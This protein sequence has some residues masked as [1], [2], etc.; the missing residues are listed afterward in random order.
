MDDLFNPYFPLRLVPEEYAWFS[1]QTDS[2]IT[3]GS[4]GQLAG[5]ADASL[6]GGLLLSLKS[7]VST[8]ASKTETRFLEGATE[9]AAFGVAKIDNPEVTIFSIFILSKDRGHV[10]KQTVERAVELT[11]SFGRELL[12]LKEL[13]AY[14]ESGKQIPEDVMLRAFLKAAVVARLNLKITRVDNNLVQEFKNEATNLLKDKKFIIDQ[15]DRFFSTKGWKIKADYW[16]DGMLKRHL[17]EGLINRLTLRILNQTLGNNPMNLLFADHKKDLIRTLE[18]IVRLKIDDLLPSPSDLIIEQ[19]PKEIKKGYG[20]S[21]AKAQLKTL[22]NVE[23]ILYNL[24]VRRALLNVMKVH[25]LILLVDLSKS[26]ISKKFN[27]ALPEVKTINVGSYF[28]KALRPLVNPREHRF[29]TKFYNLFMEELKGLEAS[30]TT[31]D[32]FVTFATAFTDLK[33]LRKEILALDDY[34]IDGRWKKELDKR[35][36][37]PKGQSIKVQSLIES[38]RLLNA[39][40]KSSLETF[41]SMLHDQFIRAFDSSIGYLLEAMIDLYL[42][43]GPIVK[44]SSVITDLITVL[45]ENPLG[46]GFFVPLPKD[47]LLV[48]MEKGEV[49]VFH[50]EKPI[51]LSKDGT[52]RLD[53]EQM[54]PNKFFGSYSY[55]V[56]Y[57]SKIYTDVWRTI[58]PEMLLGLLQSP[59]ILY[60][61]TLNS[62]IRKFRFSVI[63]VVEEWIKNF[64]SELEVADKLFGKNKIEDK[65]LFNQLQFEFFKDQTVSLEGLPFVIREI[66]EHLPERMEKIARD[67]LLVWNSI[68][69]EVNNYSSKT[70]KTWSTLKKNTL[71]ELKNFEKSLT[72]EAKLTEKLISDILKPFQKIIRNIPKTS[73]ESILNFEEGSI[74]RLPSKDF[75]SEKIQNLL[76]KTHQFSEVELENVKL[77][78]SLSIFAESPQIYLEDAYDQI[79][80]NKKSKI[81]E[82]TQKAASSKK[83]FEMLLGENA[84]SIL[85]EFYKRIATIVKS[86]EELYIDNDAP[87]FVETRAIFLQLGEVRVEDIENSDLLNSALNFP[88]IH[89]ERQ[90]TKWVIKYQ[91]PFFAGEDMEIPDLITLSDALRFITLMKFKETTDRVNEG[92]SKVLSLISQNSA[93]TYDSVM[94]KLYEVILYS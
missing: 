76:H 28:E 45:Q 61:A 23:E 69:L 73:A 71:K 2:G 82:K 36:I 33:S 12:H 47:F 53:E 24:Y 31:Y 30:Q 13:P 92:I 60:K 51:V 62:G 19:L 75:V 65:S 1:I 83:E 90:T 85:E 50:D 16:E 93:E 78:L 72:K 48:A 49:E 89:L 38:Q 22:H 91:L 37:E 46:I 84:I 4:I 94:Q 15:Y 70:R 64:K 88:D 27:E 52:I 86:V 68:S 11:W 40:I 63:N 18:E 26:K 43:I 79:I 25:P 8:E 17:K 81:V 44:V 9:H 42:Q 59:D 56:S 87:V 66:L 10:N 21:I 32:F 54:S 6:V 74:G 35:V 80:S 55:N 39:A 14:S 57:N 29:I 67:F 34:S 5:E 3:L 58:E 77:G 20:Q 7:L 41:N